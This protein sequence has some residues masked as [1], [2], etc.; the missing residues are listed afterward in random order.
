VFKAALVGLGLASEYVCLS[1]RHGA[2]SRDA[3]MDV[4]EEIAV[5]GRW[6]SLDSLCRYL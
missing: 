4:V 5:R 6:R 3:A 1:L 2:A